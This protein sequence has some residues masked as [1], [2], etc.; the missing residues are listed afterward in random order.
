M[1]IYIHESGLLMIKFR[2]ILILL[3]CPSIKLYHHF[4]FH[5]DFNHLFNVFP[6]IFPL[7]LHFIP[8]S[9]D[10]RSASQVGFPLGRRCKWCVRAAWPGSPCLTNHDWE[11]SAYHIYIYIYVYT[12]IYIQ[13]DWG[14]VYDCST[15][16][17]ADIMG[18][19]VNTQKTYSGNTKGKH[20]IRYS[21]NIM[22]MQ[23]GWNRIYW[24]YHRRL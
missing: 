10:I 8:Y 2:S 5:Y 18:E 11:W 16:Y 20:G 15:W 23:W 1:Y 13:N 19:K 24:T 7:Y 12:H 6:I 22:N 4:G 14:M 21:G 9:H 3:A 17:T